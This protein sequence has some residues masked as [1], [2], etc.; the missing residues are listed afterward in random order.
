MEDQDTLIENKG[1]DG[2]SH[3][4]RVDISSKEMR[5]DYG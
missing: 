3:L 2:V 1:G 4:R 5:P